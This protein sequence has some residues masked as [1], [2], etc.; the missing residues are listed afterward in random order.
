MN[1]VQS[2]VNCS[3]EVTFD[4]PSLPVAMSVYDDSGVTP[5]L[6][7]G[8]SAMLN[9][10]GNTYR[11][12]F[13]PTDGK[14]YIIFKAVYTNGSYTTLSPDYSQGSE[15]IQ[16]EDVAG[17]GNSTQLVAG[18]DMESSAPESSIEGTITQETDLET[19]IENEED[20]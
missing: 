1:L 9:V 15:S 18:L 5:T 20:L 12:K 13:T 6:V 11:G 14:Q 16:A 17:T 7:Q 8:P 19:E 4:S 10:V 3:F 2:G